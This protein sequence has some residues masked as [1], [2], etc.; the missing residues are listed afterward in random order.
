MTVATTWTGAG[1]QSEP[2]AP[3][4]DDRSLFEDASVPVAGG[5]HSAI[6]AVPGMHCGACVRRIEAA[7]RNERVVLRPSVATR[8][9][10]LEFDPRRTRLADLAGAMEAAGFPARPV[11]A[12]TSGELDRGTY[13]RSVKRVAVAAFLTM[14][15]MMLALPEYLAV[16]E[17]E[18]DVRRLL[19]LGQWLLATPVVFYSGWAFL[20][21]AWR[22]IRHASPSMDLPVGLALISAYGFSAWHTLTETGTVY[23]D[24]A[25]MFV[26]F[27]S[28]GRLL[29]ARGR[30][31]AAERV[32]HVLADQP[33]VARVLQGEGW[34]ERPVAQ[35]HPGVQV[36]VRP[37]E[38]IPVDGTLIENGA[39]V[40]QAVLTGEPA[41]RWFDAG[42][43]V[44]AGSVLVDEHPVRLT[45][46]AVGAETAMAAIG[47]SMHRVLAERPRAQVLADRIAGVFIVFVLLG[48]VVA[49]AAWWSAGPDRALE[50]VLA[51]LVASC[52]CAL[53][54]AVPAVLAATIGR[55]SRLGVL[56]A[57]AH[58]LLAAARI[59]AVVFDK[60][61]TL[62]EDGLVRQEVHT[63]DGLDADEALRFAAA[64]ERAST[65]PIARAFDDIDGPAAA[66]VRVERGRVSGTVE[67]K[68]VELRTADADD[69]SALGASPRPDLTWVALSVEGRLQAVFGLA[70]R[71][72]EDARRTLEDL[73]SL[74][75]RI[76]V[77]S[78]DTPE[79]AQRFADGLAV[80]VVRGGCSPED[81][82]AY[83]E[84]LRR[85]GR[86]VA[87][88][89]DG[90]N[91]SPTLAAADVGIALGTGTGL[92]QSSADAILLD[93]RLG[94]VTHLIRA[95]RSVRRRI[96]Q[97]VTW[98]LAY[99]AAVYPLAAMGFLPPWGAAIGM[100]TSSAWVVA[101]AIRPDRSLRNESGEPAGVVA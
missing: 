90:I 72:R 24:S 21:G 85:Q 95:A 66:A 51:V 7:L 4:A 54:L 16:G 39:H 64:V 83:V 40:S 80:N 32:R 28:L 37:G 45:A 59:D 62:T 98:A 86:R 88:V 101:N 78:G 96:A 19:R 6:L 18:P 9:V 47:R 17:V 63:R 60:T 91:D 1:Q 100:A 27:L 33:T 29:E 92:A 25:V 93:G 30:L 35:I 68:G 11:A 13:A 49:G 75:C 52:P 61:G 10:E 84:G 74:G 36:Q 69:L 70:A 5:R 77:L 14:Q 81:K 99:N 26:L 53:S 58:G 89:G 31:Q 20:A 46:T 67:Q 55:L 71:E 97:N 50:I 44:L 87:M 23:F 15:V 3:T 43:Q 65:H 94:G 73:Q 57:R 22:D 41:P 8:T 82:L 79:A 34:I 76:H 38:T 42:D 48:A 12:P 56:P 2:V